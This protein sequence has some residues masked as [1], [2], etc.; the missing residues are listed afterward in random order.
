[1]SLLFYTRPDYVEK[2]HAPMHASEYQSYLEKS[3][4]AIPTEL[5]FENVIANRAIPVS[6]Y[7][8]VVVKQ[9]R[10]TRGAL[11]AARFYGVLTLRGPRRGESSI[12]LMASRLYRTI[13]FSTKRAASPLACLGRRRNVF[14]LRE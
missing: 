1:M 3:R 4:A 5:C 6:R 9:L 7:E 8:Y 14:S 2:H 13:L 11:L 10:L 12:L